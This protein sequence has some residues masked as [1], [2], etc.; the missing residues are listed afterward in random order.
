MA[1]LP[2]FEYD[3]F[4]SY[5][6]NDNLDGWVTDFVQN[7]EKELKGTL[8]D[9]VTIYFDKNPHDGLL[10]THNVDK[11]LEGK[12]KCLIFI[13]I[14]SQTY[15]DPKS[16]AWQ[17]EFCAFNK[18]AKEDAFG[19]DVKVSGGNVASRILPIR[20]HDIDAEDKALLENELG[21]IL[22]PIEFIFKS[23][24]VNRPLTSSDNPDKNLNK[25]FYRD[26]VNKTAN[27]IKE[28]ITSLKTPVHPSA[29]AANTQNPTPKTQPPSIKTV[30]LITLG[31]MV[32]MALL[33][34][35]SQFMGSSDKEPEII[36]KS[37]AV[38]PFT[39]M[40]PGKDQEY[41][42]DGIAE[43]V[44]NVLAQSRDLRVIGRTSS[45]QFKGKNLDLRKIGDSLGVAYV[46]EGS[47]RKLKDQLRITAQLIKTADGSHVWS[48]GFD[49][50]A[51][52]SFDIQD[53]IA[54]TVSNSLQASLQQE[55]TELATIARNKDAYDLYLQGLYFFNKRGEGVAKGLAS[56]KQSIALDSSFAPAYSA[57]AGCYAILAQTRAMPSQEGIRESKKWADK[58]IALD[59]HAAQAFL[60]KGYIALFMENK[61]VEAQQ[62]LERSIE[63]NP[64]DMYALG[65]YCFYLIYIQGD[66]IEGEKLARKAI[67][68][69][70]LGFANH[71]SLGHTLFA[72]GEFDSGLEAFQKANDL[73]D[74]A[75]SPYTGMASILIVTKRI[76][77]ALKV[78]EKGIML[79]GR[80]PNMLLYLLHIMEIS[81]K[82]DEAVKIYDEIQGLRHEGKADF[83]S[84]GAAAA[85]I[86]RTDEAFRYFDLALEDQNGGFIFWNPFNPDP[87]KWRVSLR[88]DP[89]YQ[90]IMDRLAFPKKASN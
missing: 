15:C 7:L 38:L 24:G 4:I 55:G 1:L 61:W 23:P 26:Q 9:T 62:S 14:I 39:D 81:G 48:K 18:L 89:R 51:E 35:A 52:E 77:D 53:D 50:K 28:I 12:L 32:L 79:T 72:K 6:H 41:L 83:Y 19:R 75:S 10:E 13:P 66:P 47:V 57:L 64:N 68:L 33:Y 49:R 5:R 34:T 16:F 27:A 78:I 67:Q 58:A 71:A 80:N 21:G 25:T 36:D 65:I 54:Q 70:P 46:L 60:W 82:T 45:F 73:N 63:L 11:S 74:Q 88:K 8:K 86:G 44:I 40:S 31:L 43:E 84:L 56:L 17:H 2:G 29:P 85:A 42:G 20:I 30:S 22:R 3:I 87:D 37:I 59:P 69:D 90:K 76:D